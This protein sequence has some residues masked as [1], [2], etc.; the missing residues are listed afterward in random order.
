MAFDGITLHSVVAELQVLKGGKVNQIYQPENNNIRMSIYSGKTYLLNIDLSAS[1][2]RIHL[3]THSKRN[4]YQAPNFCM[5]LRKYLIGAKISDVYMNDLE[6]IC[7][8]TFDCFNE[9]NDKVKRV[10][11]IELMG[12]YSNVVLLNE[13]NTIID[14]LKKFDVKDPFAVSTGN[15]RSI[16]PARAYSLPIDSKNEFTK[17]SLEEFENIVKSSDYKTLDES[18]PNL[19]TGIS[20]M[21][22]QSSIE[23]LHISNTIGHGN[24]VELYHYISKIISNPNKVYCKDYAK[25]YSIYYDESFESDFDVNFFLDDYYFDKS[26]NEIYYL[27]RNNLLKVLSGTLDKLTNKLN[28]IDSKIKSCDDME[29]QKIYGELLIANIYRLQDVYDNYVEVENYY[30]NNSLTKIKINPTISISQNAEK[31]FKKYDKKKNTLRICEIQKRETERELKSLEQLVEEV[32]KCESV[33]DVDKIYEKISQNILFNDIKFKQRKP[34]GRKI[35]Q[36]EDSINNYMKLKID[37]FDVF[38]GKNNKQNDNLTLK[39]ANDNDYW[40][41]TKDIHGSHLILRCNGEMPKLA[42][43]KRCAS[44]AAYYSKA[45]FSSHVPVDYCLAK[46]VKK[47]KG[48]APGYVIYTDNKT[49]FVEP[50]CV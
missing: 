1:N 39:V 18:I 22:I 4:P 35:K 8:I 21:F 5:V 23:H 38:I 20:R 45:K 47:P 12:K 7:Y 26:E 48:S 28:N 50:E 6:R 41:H 19:F 43:I 42:T 37:D 31:Y 36:N 2:Y 24:L 40:F 49:I 15:S 10:F 16:M 11:A 25:G 34:D 33:E 9:M 46:Y 32:D 14:A 44:L 30:D 27:Y 29:K 13:S 3:S 17:T